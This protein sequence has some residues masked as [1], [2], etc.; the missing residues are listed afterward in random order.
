MKQDHLRMNN[1]TGS[2]NF[3]DSSLRKKCC[4]FDFFFYE[5]SPPSPQFGLDNLYKFFDAKNVYLSGRHCSCAA[6]QRARSAVVLTR[7][8]QVRHGGCICPILGEFAISTDLYSLFQRW[9]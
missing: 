7:A 1:S 4:S 2:N 5:L 6:R 3:K 9:R 8:A